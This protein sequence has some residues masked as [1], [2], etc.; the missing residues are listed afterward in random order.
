M[1]DY[2]DRKVRIRPMQQCGATTGCNMACGHVRR[3]A[4]GRVCQSP[5]VT[6]SQFPP[7]DVRLVP[8]HRN[9]PHARAR[10]SAQRTNRQLPGRHGAVLRVCLGQS[11]EEKTNMHVFRTIATALLV[12][13]VCPALPGPA[14]T[15]AAW[16]CRRGSAAGGRSA[17]RGASQVRCGA[18]GRGRGRQAAARRPGDG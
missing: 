11:D 1:N 12:M 7:A 18:R 2:P 17:D 3:W 4:T 13:L 6:T 14:G 10:P 5:V 9:T 16:S 8:A 15:N